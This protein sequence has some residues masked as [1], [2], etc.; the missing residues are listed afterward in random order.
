MDA[1]EPMSVERPV[2]VLPY[3]HVELD[4]LTYNQDWLACCHNTD[5][6]EEPVFAEAYQK[7]WDTGSWGGDIHWRAYVV[8]WAATQASHL[9]GIFVECGTHRGGTATLVLEVLGE[10]FFANRPF[11]L[12]DTFC[13]LSEEL[14]SPEEL[15]NFKEVY[16]DCWDFVQEHFSAYPNVQLRKGLVPESLSTL[17]PKEP[18]AFLHLDL[19]TAK[20][21]RATLKMLWPRLAPGAPVVLDDYAW[22][23]CKSQ[24]KAIDNFVRK[25]GIE[26][27]SLPTG[28]GLLFKPPI[29]GE[30]WL[31]KMALRLFW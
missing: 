14:S 26:V 27:L 29:I 10:E 20:P 16:E 1:S 23:P 13:G 12:F 22:L 17:P 8:A 9:E 3:L 4:Q 25:N 15:E 31:Q 19:N 6:A 21:E 30:T 28:Q 18:I 7:A 5:F 11:Y 2:E 24:K